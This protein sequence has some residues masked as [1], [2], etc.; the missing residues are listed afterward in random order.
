MSYLDIEKAALFKGFAEVYS[1]AGRTFVVPDDA[2]EFLNHVA[3][4]V[5]SATSEAG[6]TSL[7]ANIFNLFSREGKFPE[8]NFATQGLGD[9]MLYPAN[10]GTAEPDYM[11]LANI[12]DGIFAARS[13]YDM[14]VGELLHE[15]ERVALYVPAA[16]EEADISLYDKTKLT[17]AFAGCLYNH[18]QA[19]G[20]DPA[21]VDWSELHEEQSCLLV[22]GDISG[23]QKFIYTIPSKGALKSLRG[24]SLY[25][26]ILLEDIVDELLDM[27][28]VGR[29]CLLYNGG[30]HFYMMLPDT[31]EARSG[32]D[33]AKDKLND[34]FLRHYRTHLYLA[35]AYVPCSTDELLSKG[36]VKRNIFREVSGEL[37]REKL[38]RYSK[39]SLAKLINPDSEYN[40]GDGSDRECAI[41]RST[42][43]ADELE[44]YGDTDDMDNGHQTLAC[45][46]CRGLY[47]LGQ[48]AIEG[49]VFCISDEDDGSSV[50]LPGLKGDMYLHV[51]SGD[52]LQGLA[53]AVRIYTKN[54]GAVSVP[55]T[56]QLWMGDYSIRDE[57]GGPVEFA[58]IAQESG[59]EADSAS[60]PRLGVLRADVDNL[61]AAF[62]SGFDRQHDSLARKAALSR[63]LSMFFKRYI[64]DI[65]EGILPDGITGFTMF[66]GETKHE[67]KLHIIYSG[68][69]DL[70]LVGT[71]DDII[72]TAVDIRHAF[73]VFTNGKLTFSAGIGLFKPSCPISE[74]ARATGE[75]EDYAKAVE[76][77]NSLAIF[78]RV[79]DVHV[80]GDAEYTHRF[81]WDDFEK[82]VC[83][84]KLRF[85]EDNITSPKAGDPTKV[86]AGKSALYRLLMLLRNAGDGRNMNLARLAY[87]LARMEPP[88][89]DV[90]RQECYNR[91]R[92]KIYDWYQSVEDRQQLVTAIEL[93]VY[94]IRE[95]EGLH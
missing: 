8:T 22:S 33:A 40:K 27:A 74:M 25:L 1:R 80:D 65:C 17:A 79:K 91:V 78:G 31:A 15:L 44:P 19:G 28:G 53:G 51:V 30:G 56:A 50:P 26:D 38:C 63:Q 37:G 81:M 43:P 36:K 75:L 11:E 39:E 68:G 42:F 46:S 71:W 47:R 13:P 21:D 3:D 12:L 83:G 73:K 92:D 29:S 72:E 55:I 94:H 9:R 24:R 2:A 6:A 76:T 58:T 48:M 85:L 77:K 61:G 90:A 10:G 23:I 57:Y 20:K 70:F 88:K 64:N 45:P 95:K 84:E 49:D 69:D 35:M 60:I 7:L 41:C 66:K 89:K 34:W 67:R 52:D 16:G 5:S 59:G 93:Y 82:G 86:L 18:L 87:T 62:I 4:A 32:L 14:S 54:E